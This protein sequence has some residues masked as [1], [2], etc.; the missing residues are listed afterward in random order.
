MKLELNKGIT[1]RSK[2]NRFITKSAYS[3]LKDKR[4]KSDS[5]FIFDLTERCISADGE[6]FEEHDLVRDEGCGCKRYN[7][8]RCGKVYIP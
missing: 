7:C 5:K 8:I 2:L 4:I 1:V 3:A 6:V